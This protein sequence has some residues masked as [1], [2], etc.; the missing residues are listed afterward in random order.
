MNLLGSDGKGITRKM[1]ETMPVILC[2][3]AHAMENSLGNFREYTEAFERYPHLAGGF[4]WDFVDQSIRQKSP[5]GEERWLYGDDFAEIYDPQNGLKRRSAVG[6]NRYFCANGIIAANRELHP[7]AYEVKKCYQVVEALPVKPA[8]GRYLIRNKQLFRDLSFYRLC[9]S[10]EAGGASIIAE[11]EVPQETL[12][13]IPPGQEKEITIPLSLPETGDLILTFRWLLR[14]KKAWADAGYEA[15]V[16]QII[17]R[18]E[19]AATSGASEAAAR[20]LP[21][22]ELLSRGAGADTPRFDPRLNERIEVRAGSIRYSF[23]KGM[24]VSAVRDNYEFLSFPVRPNYYRPQTDNDRGAANFFAGL[25]PLT[26]GEKW[27]RGGRKERA[28]STEILSGEKPGTL[29]ITVRW[30]HPLLRAAQTRYTLRGDGSLE[31]EHRAASKKIPLQR[32]GLTLALP[33]SFDAVEWHGR[34]P[35]ENYPDRKTGAWIG[36]HRLSVEEL[37]HRYMR[38]QENGARCDLDFL[39][40][41][42]GGRKFIL[43]DL[44]GQ[45]MI[46]SAR[47]YTNEAL[48][49]AEHIHELKAEDLTTL[50]IDG[51]MCGVGGDLPGMA[52][53]HKAYILPAGQTYY[54]RVRLELA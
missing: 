36:R 4:V 7:S 10:L 28:V 45:G 20:S 44:S 19:S 33:P 43:R 42:G 5:G 13:D 25:L 23:E 21:P 30:K 15:A 22:P 50:N 53:L 31:I 14:E 54:L 1:Y 49:A 24:L 18:K 29:T 34:G 48:D 27:K 52:V 40:L 17:L 35:H 2:E 9:W 46:F 39:C 37:E 32:L 8:E 26:A 12:R 3:F 6:S 38:P 41:S 11:G 47:R 51:A 16:D